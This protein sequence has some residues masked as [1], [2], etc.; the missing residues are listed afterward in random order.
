MILG[1]AIF[2]AL[3]SLIALLSL[4]TAAQRGDSKIGSSLILLLAL[5]GTVLAIWN[6]P[7]WSHPSHQTTEE[8]KKCHSRPAHRHFR[9][10]QVQLK[11][12]PKKLMSRMLSNNLLNH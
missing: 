4:L 1:F 10:V 7:Y 5:C 6:L 3:I 8:A 12:Q 11:Q 2:G 9:P